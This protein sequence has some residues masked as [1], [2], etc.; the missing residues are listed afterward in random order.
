VTDFQRVYHSGSNRKVR[1][2]RDQV[3]DNT[4]LDFT[5]NGNVRLVTTYINKQ[6]W[7]QNVNLIEVQ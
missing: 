7:T 3:D 6:F 2:N 1:L 4:L 5:E